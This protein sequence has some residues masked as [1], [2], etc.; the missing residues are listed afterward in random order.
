ME[1][2]VKIK[3][4]LVSVNWLCQN[5]DATNLIVLNGTLPK[6]TAKEAIQKIENKCIPKARF[7][8][9]KKV[10]SLQG[11]QFPNTVLEPIDF[12]SKARALGINKDSC[13]VVYDEH[14]IYS[15]PRVWWLFKTMGFDNVAVL[16][17]GFPTWKE[18]G[19]SIE[20]KQ[21]HPSKNGNFTVNYIVGLMLNSNSVLNSLNDTTKQI[22]D[23]RSSGR[24]YATVPEPRAEI[25]SGHIPNSKSLPHSSLLNDSE[26]KS[27]AEL[28][29]LFKE[30][31]L[32]NN[33]LIFSCGSGITACVLALGATVAGFDN[34]AVYDGSWTEWGSLQHLPIE[35]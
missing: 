6:V 28:Q 26:L 23:A 4:P 5:I 31:N 18:A 32:E 14:G 25:R 33:T 13:I 15:A 17:G 29:E 12:E 21:E 7:F 24:F 10:F 34:L 16:D 35:K 3:S 9:L 8:D 22:V 30:V 2:K 20:E 27:T 1:K 19:Y 11:A